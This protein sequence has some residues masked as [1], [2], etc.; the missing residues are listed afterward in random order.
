MASRYCLQTIQHKGHD[1]DK[2]SNVVGRIE[3]HLRSLLAQLVERKKIFGKT[4]SCIDYEIEG[5]MRL[6]ELRNADL[7][8]FST[9]VTTGV[10]IDGG[11]HRKAV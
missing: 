2:L 4:L 1:F 3:E 5:L 9:T 6:K 10:R 8:K 11:K 7:E